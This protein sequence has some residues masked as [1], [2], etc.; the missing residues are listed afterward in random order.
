[1]REPV[2]HISFDPIGAAILLLALLLVATVL[3]LATSWYWRRRCARSS[4]FMVGQLDALL[5]T[6]PLGLLLTNREGQVLWCNPQ[7]RQLL[8]LDRT[9]P[10]LDGGLVSLVK[11]VAESRQSE[12]HELQPSEGV[13]LQLR[14]MP[15]GGS[16]PSDEDAVI[17]M[18]T[19]VSERRHQG[20][21]YRSFIQNISHELLTP[22]AAI[23]GHVANIK[24][25]SIEEVESWRLSQDIIER[26][27]RR[28]TGLTSNLLLLSR[29]ESGVPLR[30]EPTNVGVVVEEAVAGLLRVAQAKGIELSIQ[31]PPRL[32]RT[33]ADR[34]RIKQVFIN[35][36]DNA[37][38]YCPEGSEVR[39]RLGTDGESIIVEV[40]DDGPGIPPEDL[41]H[42]FDKMYRVEKEG[43]RAVKG[44]GLGLSIVKRIVELHG[45]QIAVESV[46]GEGTTFRVRLPLAGEPM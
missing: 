19:D 44:S 14:A 1:M 36:L 35:L 16:S 20:E 31:S 32:P 21:F 7:T 3:V 40:A 29:L 15:V 27:V 42:I 12:L 46:E 11:R 41:P 37:V 33:R 13:Q 18:V 8:S 22:L 28:L 10:R 23:A 39:V 38:K 30:F 25:C 9:S 43:T 5:D 45:G 6:L 4:A 24:E 2:I 34:D 17:C 26:E